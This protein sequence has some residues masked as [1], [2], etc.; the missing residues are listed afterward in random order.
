MS[1]GSSVHYNVNPDGVVKLKTT[2]EG[3]ASREPTTVYKVFEAT[4][5]KFGNKKALCV[6]R[7]ENDGWV[8]WTWRQYFDDCLAAAKS[9]IKLG[10][11]PQYAVAI[12]GFNSPEWFIAD[13]GAILAGGF[14]AGIYTTNKADACQYVANHARAQ[15]IVAEDQAQVAKIMSVKDELP[16]LKHIIQYRGEVSA[17]YKDENVMDWETFM[18]VGNMVAEHD[19]MWRINDQK[20][21]NCC[22]L[23]YTSGTTGKPKAVMISHDSLTWTAKATCIAIGLKEGK[24]HGISYL[25]LSHIAAQMLD[26]VAPMTHGGTTWFAKP[27]ALKG[28]L[29]ATLTDVR[30]T[31][32]L[33]V[34]RV[35]EKFEEAL[36][37][38]GGQATGLKKKI[39]IWAKAKG[40]EGNMSMQEGGSKPFGF[41]L[42]KALVFKKVR[43]ALGLTRCR[44][45]ATAA[46]PITRET[47]D[48]F[49]ALDMPIY[50]IYGM[51]ECTG[52]Q[53]IS[54]KG[55]HKTGKCGPVFEGAEMMIDNPDEDG[56]GEVCFRGRHIM[57]GYLNNEEKTKESIDDD[58]WLHSGDIGK[59]D[60]DGF[61]SITGRIKEMLITAGGENVPPV[62]IEDRVKDA[63]SIISNVMVIGDKRKFLSMLVTL[64]SGVDM[65]TGVPTDKLTPDVIAALEAID[66]KAKT[67]AEAIAD[68]KLKPYFE[69]GLKQA[70]KGAT[71][72]AQ[73]VK[74]YTILP[75]DFSIPGG[76]LGPTLKLKRPV[77]Y[78]KYEA[79]MEAMYA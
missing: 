53:T 23:I 79:E 35:W 59:V 75:T 27:D 15:I 41:G 68:E 61:L 62:P 65:A 46:A 78:Q 12:I 44:F 69:A 22:T 29:K 26:V 37:A 39:A 52:P 77:V 72:N 42:A 45:L 48:F 18:K 6:Q 13:V 4:A 19:L 38:V 66:S 20:P 76:E 73:T 1:D 7:G 34:P 43:K 24:E 58:G 64:K 28:S 11:E 25:P 9:F 21:G 31:F 70:N 49:L 2:T 55:L 71:S 67:V 3:I 8:Y 54:M 60:E 17:D 10:L 30:P 16:H 56:N 36:K 40:L 47:L 14:A 5:E 63:M 74:K 57:M 50:E 32:F 51:S 33:G